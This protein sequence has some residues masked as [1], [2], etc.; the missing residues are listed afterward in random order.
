MAL[1]GPPNAGKSSVLNRL[2]GREAAIVAATEGTTRDLL[3]VALDLGGYK[4]PIMVITNSNDTPAGSLAFGHAC[5]LRHG[6]AL[7]CCCPH[8]AFAVRRPT[9]AKGRGHTPGGKATNTQR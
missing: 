8:R 4:V 9:P 1:V 3:E 5:P 7:E 2:T 6:G